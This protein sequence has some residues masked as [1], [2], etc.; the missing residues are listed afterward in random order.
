MRQKIKSKILMMGILMLLFSLAAQPVL[1]VNIR[2]CLKTGVSSTE[3]RVVA[4]TYQINGGSLSSTL[5]AEADEGAVIRTVRNG[6]TIMVYVNG[7]Q[8]QFQRFNFGC[9][10]RQ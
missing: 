7:T 6:S 9:G 3:M 1:A 2:V 5:M 10:Q 4:G 8:V